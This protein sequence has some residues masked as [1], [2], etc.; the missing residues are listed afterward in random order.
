MN[1]Y[2]DKLYEQFSGVRHTRNEAERHKLNEKLAKQAVA[3]KLFIIIM[4]FYYL[5]VDKSRGDLFLILMVIYFL[6]FENNNLN[7]TPTHLTWAQR[8]Q[9]WKNSI[10]IAN[11][12][13]LLAVLVINVIL[14]ALLPF[15]EH[16]WR[17]LVAM[18]LG[19]WLCGAVLLNFIFLI[20]MF[21][22]RKH[23]SQTRAA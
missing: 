9:N 15:D 4:F 10:R 13:L 22:I 21:V 3:L 6:S 2:L 19:M 11:G 7:N 17:M 16:S 1:K 14:F 20:Q 23:L 18:I 12:I 8:W 5:L